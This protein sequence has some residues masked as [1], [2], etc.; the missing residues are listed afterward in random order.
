MQRRD[1][2]KKLFEIFCE[3]LHLIKEFNMKNIK[4]YFFLFALFFTSC[5]NDIPLNDETWPYFDGWRANT[6]FATTVMEGL[7]L[8]ISTVLFISHSQWP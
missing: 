8:R 2:A 1:V 3:S 7:R 4:K 6:R 5:G